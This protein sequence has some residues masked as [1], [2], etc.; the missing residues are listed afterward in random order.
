MPQSSD[1]VVK[2]VDLKRPEAAQVA[3][4]LI[5]NGRWF[6]VAPQPSGMV[7][8]VVLAAAW[9]ALL[10][11]LTELGIEQAVSPERTQA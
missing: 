9:A 1:Y 5:E 3:V 10:A 7:R 4:Q 8:V 11:A 6:E 2:Y